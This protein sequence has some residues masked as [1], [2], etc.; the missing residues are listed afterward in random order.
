MKMAINMQNM[1]KE[2]SAD[3]QGGSYGKPYQG[4]I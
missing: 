2:H 4:M 3:C 1:G